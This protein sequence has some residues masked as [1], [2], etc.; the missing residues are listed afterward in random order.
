VEDRLICISH[1]MTFIP[2]PDTPFIRSL[3]HM[4]PRG[5]AKRWRD[6][7]GK[8]IY[9]WDGLHGELEVYNNK[10]YHMGVVDVDGILIK[11][12]VPGRRIDV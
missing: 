12:A 2:P 7:A 11:K 6:Q 8:R 9:E 4:P 3:V 5:R 1:V 10:G